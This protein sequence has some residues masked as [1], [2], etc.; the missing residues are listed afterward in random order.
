[1]RGEAVCMVYELQG[2]GLIFYGNA[3][4]VVKTLVESG[5][6]VCA[7]LNDVRA[8]GGHSEPGPQRGVGGAPSGGGV[9]GG[10]TFGSPMSR[11]TAASTSSFPGSTSDCVSILIDSALK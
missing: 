11:L 7:T 4:D 9:G 8:H 2:E 1:L 6:T 3:P 5:W 10:G